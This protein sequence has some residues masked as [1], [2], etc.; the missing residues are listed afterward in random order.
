MDSIT[1]KRLSRA[2]AAIALSVVVACTST[3]PRKPPS[4]KTF[5]T[6][7]YQGGRL[8]MFEPCGCSATPYG[9]LDREYNAVQVARKGE[10]TVIYVD[11]GN[12]F[13]PDKLSNNM[14]E[15]YQRKALFMVRMLST[16]GLDAL[17]PGPNDYQLGIEELK[18]ASKE[19]QFPFIS[20][21]V[22]LKGD[23]PFKKSTAFDRDGLKVVVVS[24]TPPG[25]YG[26][27]E[28]GNPVEAI[29]SELKEVGEY[30]LLVVLSQ[31][32]L[33]ENETLAETF[34]QA[35]VVGTEPKVQLEEPVWKKSGIVLDPYPN[36]FRLGR[37]Q[38][39]YKKPFKGFSSPSAV[40]NNS[41]ELKTWEKL[42]TSKKKKQADEAKT[43]IQYLRRSQQLE[44]VEGGSNYANYHLEL[45]E[46]RFGQPNKVT[47]QM[48]SYKEAVRKAAIESAP[49]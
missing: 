42:Q 46:K 31:L 2:C 36:G 41:A 9:G 40:L 19:A 26:S 6:F 48:N 14:I 49:R 33:A 39:T 32:S 27:A 45:D 22:T 25:K 1:R 38:M 20:T 28:A 10:G 24:A 34:R 3:G 21:N 13:A 11:A 16:N 8:G 12:A 37:L 18:N 47:E 4:D 35:L 43:M 29:K 17:S 44:P 15:G 5:V 30:D 7:L 23:P